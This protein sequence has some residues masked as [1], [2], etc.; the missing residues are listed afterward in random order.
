MQK[1]DKTKKRLDMGAVTLRVAK[2]LFSKLKA[3]VAFKLQ[4]V[5]LTIFFKSEK[6]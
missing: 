2:H 1:N 6:I 5:V 3:A 4:N